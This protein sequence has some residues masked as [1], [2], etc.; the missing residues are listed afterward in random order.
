MADQTLKKDA[1]KPALDL[2][3][4]PD[5]VLTDSDVP[6]ETMYGA[7]QAWYYGAPL[8]LTLPIP[9]RHIPGMA[10]VLGFGAAKYQPRGW[11]VGIPYSRVFAAAARHAEADYRGEALDPETGFPHAW[12][13]WCN[14]MFLVTY[15]ARGRADLDDRPPA[16]P[17]VRDMLDRI[18]AFAAQTTGNGVMAPGPNPAAKNGIN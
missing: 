1:G 9:R 15:A 3:P 17:R 13:F 14:V 11:E 7:L 6:V 18:A 10:A 12:H 5:L 8:A 16:S 4:F 2:V